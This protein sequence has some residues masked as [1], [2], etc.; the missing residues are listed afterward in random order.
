MAL[1]PE[2]IFILG[3]SRPAIYFPENAGLVFPRKNVCFSVQ[4]QLFPR[5]KMVF[6]SKTKIVLA[7]SVNFVSR[8]CTLRIRVA[9]KVQTHDCSDSIPLSVHALQYLG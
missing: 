5:K 1:R 7:R 6:H 4:N 2:T 3:K 9:N 8:L